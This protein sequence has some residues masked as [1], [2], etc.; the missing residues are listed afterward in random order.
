MVNQFREMGMT[1]VVLVCY[2]DSEGKPVVNWYVRRSLFP[3]YE[4]ITISLVST[5][6]Q[7]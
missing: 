1:S 4:I 2:K 5:V 3:E 6:L 7:N